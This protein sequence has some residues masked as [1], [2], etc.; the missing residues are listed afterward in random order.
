MSP[1]WTSCGRASSASWKRWSAPGAARKPLPDGAPLP[2]APP[3]QVSAWLER[4]L[5]VVPPGTE[6]EQ[7]GIDAA[8]DQLLAQ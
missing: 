1:I 5:R 8:L 6:G 3:A 2:E 4:T 7:L